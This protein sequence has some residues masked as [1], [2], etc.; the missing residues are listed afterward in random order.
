MTLAVQ[1]GAARR[2]TLEEWAK[3]D[4]DEPGELV[5]GLLEEEEVT[6]YLHELVAAYLLSMLFG[7]LVARGGMAFGSEGK[8]RT[9]PRGGRKPD[10]SVYFPGAK[11]PAKR[12][13]MAKSPPSIAIEVI[14]PTPRDVRRDRVTKRAEYAALGVPYYW[15]VDP[16]SRSIEVLR[17][18]NGV[19]APLVTAADGVLAVPGC[20]GVTLDLDAMWSCADKLTD[21]EPPSSRRRKKAAPRPSARGD[22]VKNP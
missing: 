12:S 7:Q 9:G 21:E 18:E 16:E 17:L 3:L 5:D 8:V 10:L 1:T 19:Y 20:D 6:T 22:A 11:L 13:R 2:M 4:S 14:T 15:L